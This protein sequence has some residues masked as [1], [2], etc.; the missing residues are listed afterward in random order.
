MWKSQVRST[1]EHPQQ[2]Q[3]S[4]WNSSILV[5]L[6]SMKHGLKHVKIS[7]H[8]ILKKYSATVYAFERSHRDW[9]HTVYC[10]T[11]RHVLFREFSSNMQRY[12]H[13]NN[14]KCVA[15]QQM[16]VNVTIEVKCCCVGVLTVKCA[17]LFILLQVS[18]TKKQPLRKY[19][20]SAFW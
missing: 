11:N 5:F 20:L 7:Q 18:L 17:D 6:V 15:L 10:L 16:V 19:F 1:D 4:V 3:C 14:S 13:C 8:K 12:I 9:I 2:Y